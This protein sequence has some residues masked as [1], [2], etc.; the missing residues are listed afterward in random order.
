MVYHLVRDEETFKIKLKD[1][2]FLV[3]CADLLGRYHD[4]SLSFS[5]PLSNRL[6]KYFDDED[7]MLV[8]KK[9]IM[10]ELIFEIL[11]FRIFHHLFYCNRGFYM[12]NK[13]VFRTRFHVRE[14]LFSD[15][16]NQKLKFSKSYFPC[17]FVHD[18]FLNQ[19]SLFIHYHGIIYANTDKDFENIYGNFGVLYY[20]EVG[21]PFLLYKF[22]LEILC[23]VIFNKFFTKVMPIM[24]NDFDLN[25]KKYLQ[26]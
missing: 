19:I 18:V 4:K 22:Y 8:V 2:H 6:Q 11:P 26:A 5:F 7:L 24:F 14:R 13:C 3:P 17:N 12:N 1:S 15:F 25:V 10:N 9:K 20:E 16:L 23:R 21:R